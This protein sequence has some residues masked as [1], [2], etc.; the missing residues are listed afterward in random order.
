MSAEGTDMAEQ[1][2]FPL[3]EAVDFVIIGSGSAGGIL[4]RE[5]SMAGFEVVVLEQ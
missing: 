5:L 4:A 1:P 2:R 3:G